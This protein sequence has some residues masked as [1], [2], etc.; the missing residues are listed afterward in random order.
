MQFVQN[1]HCI[2]ISCYSS[3]SFHPNHTK[4]YI[5]GKHIYS[6]DCKSAKFGWILGVGQILYRVKQKKMVHKSISY[7]RLHF[8]SLLGLM[9]KLSLYLESREK[10]L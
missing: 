2:N 5:S 4:V 10:T 6:E 7:L 3:K 8:V 1:M 9:G